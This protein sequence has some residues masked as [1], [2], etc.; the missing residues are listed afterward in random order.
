MAKKPRNLQRELSTANRIVED[1][2]TLINGL[3][4]ALAKQR[5]KVGDM[6]AQVFAH[7]ME[8]ARLSGYIDRVREVEGHGLEFSGAGTPLNRK[9]MD[10]FDLAAMR[11]RLAN[12]EPKDFDRLMSEMDDDTLERVTGRDDDAP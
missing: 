7:K 4:V 11:E 9:S 10:Q 1:N 5:S 6:F 12:S 8:I 2:S 3:N